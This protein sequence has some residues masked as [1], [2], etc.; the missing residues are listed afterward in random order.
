MITSANAEKLLKKSPI[1][2]Q[3]KNTK[4][5]GIQKETSSIEYRASIEKSTTSIIISGEY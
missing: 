2:F 5:L 4:K 1:P 3:Y